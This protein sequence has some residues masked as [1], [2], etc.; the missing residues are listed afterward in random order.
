[1]DKRSTR[2]SA[3]KGIKREKYSRQYAFSSKMKCAFCGGTIGRRSW[4]GNTKNKKVV[5]ACITGTKKGKKYCPHSKGISEAEI[6]AAFVDAFNTLTTRNRSMVEEFLQ[7]IEETIG[8]STVLKQLKKL[9]DEIENLNY[10][11][12]KLV[13][14]NIEGIINKETYEE[15][16]HATTTEL[17]RAKDDLNGLDDAYEQ[18]KQLKDKLRSFRRAFDNN[19][20][21]E[22]FDREIFEN[23]IDHVIVGKENED[24]TTNPYSVTFVFKAG[25]ESEED[26]SAKKAKGIHDKHSDIM[27]S[28]NANDTFT[29]QEMLH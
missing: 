19:E 17:E 24:G 14:M 15:K 4:H 3:N 21:L 5:W 1:M 9:N 6:E 16:Y 13:E 28:H 8:E 18:E 7:N 2:R 11:L 27:Y 10:K 22:S 20:V 25:M 29:Q 26:I 12:G 23:V